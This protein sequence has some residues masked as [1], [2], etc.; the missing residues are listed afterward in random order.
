MK[1][2]LVLLGIYT[3]LV[4]S[5][6]AQQLAID[7]VMS[8]DELKNTGVSTLSQVQRKELDRWLNRYSHLLLAEKKKNNEC[9]PAFETHIEGEFKGWS[10]E[11]IYKLGNGQIWQQAT[12]HYHYHYAYAPDVT[13][14]AVAGG[15]A[16]RVS[17]DD[18]ENIPVRRLK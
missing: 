3:V 9:D 1:S 18:D 6:T 14:F 2:L 8:S 16:I 10:G 17:D 13:V 7:Q 15:C 12:Y 11:T 4:I 5:A